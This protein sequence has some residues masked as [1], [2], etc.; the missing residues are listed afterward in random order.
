M[1]RGHD[2]A[3]VE[4]KSDN[5]PPADL[6]HHDDWPENIGEHPWLWVGNTIYKLSETGGYQ[7]HSLREPVSSTKAA[8]K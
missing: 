8:R 2:G 5:K 3:S 4:K 1:N 7:Q 6:Q